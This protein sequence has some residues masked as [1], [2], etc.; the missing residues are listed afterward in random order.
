MRKKIIIHIGFPKTGTS[1][2]QLHLFPNLNDVYLLPTRDNPMGDL[3][4]SQMYHAQNPLLLDLN[5]IKE[6][7]DTYIAKI[8]EQTIIISNENLVGCEY[9]NFNDNKYISEILKYVFPNAKIL[10][11]FRRQDKYL[12]DLYLQMLRKRKCLRINRFLNFK[13]GRF[14]DYTKAIIS[15]PNIS[16]RTLDWNLFYRNYVN[17]FSRENVLFLPY[18]LLKEN[19]ELFI[20]NIVNFIGTKKLYPSTPNIIENRSYSQLSAYVALILNYIPC[21]LP[22]VIS[23]YIYRKILDSIFYKEANFI[24]KEK[25]DKILAFHGCNNKQLERSVGIDL[26]KYHY[27]D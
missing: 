18:E 3:M 7:I 8:K 24:N 11:V 10:L 4:Y 21:S 20:E 27:Y 26:K 13:D 9:E 15:K 14:N 2:L 19:S 16:I 25:K 5:T 12:N 6:K 22:P 23:K 17:L 1:F